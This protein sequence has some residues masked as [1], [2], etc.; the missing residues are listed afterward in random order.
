MQF[1][2]TNHLG[3]LVDFYSGELIEDAEVSIEID[4]KVESNLMLMDAKMESGVSAR[5]RYIDNIGK[6]QESASILLRKYAENNR[7]KM[8][9]GFRAYTE[10][11]NGGVES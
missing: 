9:G 5:Q 8:L 10:P 7:A 11:D 2:R 1:T 4:G 3:Q 6:P